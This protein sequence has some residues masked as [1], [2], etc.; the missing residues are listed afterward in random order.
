AA[1]AA[2]AVGERRRDRE[3][4]PAA[5]AHPLH[6]LIPAGDHLA[7]A[8]LEL[9]RRPAVPRGVE[10]LAREER[11]ADVVDGHLPPARRLVPVAGGEVLD[12]ELEGNVTPRL[13]DL[14]PLEAH[15]S[16]PRASRV[17]SFGESARRRQRPGGAWR[18]VSG[19]PCGRNVS[20]LSRRLAK[21]HGGPGRAR[22]GGVTG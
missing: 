14:R 7:L 11:D 16:H 21:R 10:L 8:E 9:E 18:P 19:S 3:L 2:R 17:T 5:H 22:A 20:L 4:P 6:A 13:L 15:P 12:H 1:C